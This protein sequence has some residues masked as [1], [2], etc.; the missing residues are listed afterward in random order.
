MAAG[1]FGNSAVTGVFVGAG[2]AVAGVHVHAVAGAVPSAVAARGAAGSTASDLAAS[3]AA[4][5]AAGAAAANG[6]VSALA[7]GVVSTIGEEGRA[8]N[9]T[10]F[11]AGSA[12]ALAIPGGTLAD[13]V[14]SIAGAGC[15]VYL[16]SVSMDAGL[17]AARS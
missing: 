8:A 14:R 2:C 4:L 13:T 11:P 17:L 5:D 7:R 15:A 12:C 1:D 9:G 6:L 16:S 10:L 3:S